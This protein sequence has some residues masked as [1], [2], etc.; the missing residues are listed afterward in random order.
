MS[1]IL[2]SNAIAGSILAILPAFLV[3]IFTARFEKSMWIS[4]IFGGLS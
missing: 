2:S 1:F 3:F 4:A